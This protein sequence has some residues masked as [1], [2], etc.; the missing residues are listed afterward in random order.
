MGCSTLHIKTEIECRV[1]LF[2]EEKGIATPDSYFNLEVR[3]GEQ[4]LLFVS[5]EDETL[6]CQM[7]Y[8]VEENDYDYRMV[9]EKSQFKQMSIDELVHI[10]E[11]GNADAQ[12]NL[13]IC[14]EKGKG[15]NVDFAEADKWFCKAAAKYKKDAEQDDSYA[16][17][18]LA[19][20][21]EY[22]YGVMQDYE[23]AVKW[24]RKSIMND[25]KGL[26]NLAQSGIERI[27]GVSGFI[28]T[29][30][31]INIQDVYSDSRFSRGVAKTINGE[32]D[33]I[34]VTP[35]IIG[36]NYGLRAFTKGGRPIVKSDRLLV[37]KKKDEFHALIINK[38]EM[39][40]IPQ[41]NIY[42][43]TPYYIFFDTET[44]GI[45]NDYTAPASDTNN[46]PRL[47]QLSWILTDKDGC[48]MKIGN[49]I[50]RPDGFSIPID[51]ANV[52]GITTEKAIHIGKPLRDV[53][54]KFLNDAKQALF[55]VGHNISFD[56]RVIGAEL[57]RLGM[58]DIVSN[59]RSICT[60]QSTVD[61]CKI[62]GY[63][64]YKYPQ[65]QELYRKLFGCNFE[66]AH[67]AMA[68]ITA[69]KKCFFEL[70]RI[71]VI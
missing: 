30:C 4:D 31:E 32:C 68:D 20:C 60:M 67:D 1:F 19:I 66:D 21:Y 7:L 12:F 16:Q 70:K 47:V 36:A 69:T 56:Q 49:E 62:P 29:L 51:A 14:Y 23:E 2:D 41:L 27:Q 71:G 33:F 39:A 44:T 57:Y 37:W 58:S 35:C 18:H 50:V 40:E 25:T 22:G 24:Y 13:G 45:P 3:K 9:I 61:Y 17:Y 43:R 42:V 11:S 34:Y 46:W 64:G 48:T 38:T 55:L 65:L 52:H 26:I 59:R 53:I 28:I 54:E 5:T 15:V 8:N 10:A 6:R 63:Y